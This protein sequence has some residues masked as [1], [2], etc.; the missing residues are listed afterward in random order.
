MSWPP[1]FLEGGEGLLFAL[2]KGAARKWVF[3]LYIM[4]EVSVGRELRKGP[5]PV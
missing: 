3:K 1:I 2:E 5:D 4:A